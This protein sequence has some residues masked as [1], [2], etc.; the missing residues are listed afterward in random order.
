[1]VKSAE[2]YL[3]F[4]RTLGQL[5]FLAHRHHDPVEQKEYQLKYNSLRL[6]EIDYKTTE[7]SEE[8]KIELTCLD[9]LIALYD[10]YNSEVSDMRRSEIHNEIIA[11]SE[12][13]RVAR[14]T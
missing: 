12:Q 7:L 10:Q 4:K 11:L 3:E 2:N 1:M 9:L 13:L 5:L 6:K 8:Q 14:D